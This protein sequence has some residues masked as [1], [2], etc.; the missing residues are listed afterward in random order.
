M[1]TLNGNGH[2]NGNGNGQSPGNGHSHGNDNA[3][4]TEPA[5]G[6]TPSLINLA[7]SQISF[8]DHEGLLWHAVPVRFTRQSV[9][10]EI[11]H[12]EP[13]VTLR[14]SAVLSSFQLVLQQRVIYQGRAVIERVMDSGAKIVCEAGLAETGWQ[15]VKLNGLLHSETKLKA[16]FDHFVFQWQKQNRLKPDYKMAV[17]ELRGFLE[18]LRLWLDQIDVEL[19][20]LVAEEREFAEQKLGSQILQL[21]SPIL[22]RLFGQFEAAAS[23]LADD[24]FPSHSN[25]CRQQLHSQL[26]C[27]PFMHR[28][29][30]KP[31]G[32]AGD[33]EMIDMII[34]NELEGGSLF[35][36][37]LQAYILDQSPARSVRNRAEYFTRKFSE[38]LARV[39]SRPNETAS[40]FSLGC[41]PAREVEAFLTEQPLSEH[42][43]F[44]LLDFSQETLKKTGDNLQ[45]VRHLHGRRTPVEMVHNSVNS[46]L[47]DSVR[48]RQPKPEFDFIYC[49]GLYDYL[50]DKVCKQLNSSLYDQLKPGG[51]LVVT[52]FAPCNPIRKIMEH[53]FDWFL[54]H[55]DGAQLLAV[56]PEQASLDHCRVIADETGCNVFLEV[57][58]PV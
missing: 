29:F 37:M 16:E 18:E 56:A 34:R 5:D 39:R 20:L 55:R 2:G 8:Q 12:P 41:G 13:G 17:L 19:R 28:I 50:T 21:I 22:A 38:E 23:K 35:A 58:K 51:Q 46:V 33:F 4:V 3:P 14:A 24:E 42:A 48:S 54:I 7:G 40:F 32:Y 31:M 36:K 30:A 47:S 27:C 57:R 49:S 15:G 6:E 44:R 11:Y 45:R 25:F 52:N 43:R 1:S 9:V 10:F 53:I 26:L